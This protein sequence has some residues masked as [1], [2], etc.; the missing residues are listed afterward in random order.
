MPLEAEGFSSGVSSL[1]E[2]VLPDELDVVEELDELELLEEALLTAMS[3][4]LLVTVQSL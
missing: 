2:E 1:E 3:S 4:L